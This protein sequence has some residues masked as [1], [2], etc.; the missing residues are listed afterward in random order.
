MTALHFIVD[1][2]LPSHLAYWLR[3][4]K[5]A[6]THVAFENLSSSPDKDIWTWA[7]RHKAIEISKDQDFRNRVKPGEG[8]RLIWIR[9][10]NTRKQ[11]LIRRLEIIWPQVVAAFDSGETLIEL[12]DPL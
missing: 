3:E 9:W 8:P 7:A 10:G 5:H 6:A 1:E 11:D 12:A 4:K 2:N